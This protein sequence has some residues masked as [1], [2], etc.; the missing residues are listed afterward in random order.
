MLI[1]H[2]CWNNYEVSRRFG[3][4]ILKGLNNTNELEVKPFVECM[5]MYL[6]L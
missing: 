5:K 1:A 4:F 6:S 3:K 2:L